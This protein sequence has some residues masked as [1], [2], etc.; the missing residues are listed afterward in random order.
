LTISK[1]SAYSPPERKT[2]AK[3]PVPRTGLRSTSV[4]HGRL[5][6][7]EAAMAVT[8]ANLPDGIRARLSVRAPWWSW[9]WLGFVYQP[10]RG[11]LQ[12]TR[13]E[14]RE[15][16]KWYCVW[17]CTVTQT[18]DVPANT[19]RLVLEGRAFSSVGATLEQLQVIGPTE[20]SDCSSRTLYAHN[21][22]FPLP[23]WLGGGFKGVG[24]RAQVN[25]RGSEAILHDHWGSAGP[26]PAD[27]L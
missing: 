1:G 19:D 17:L 26:M 7:K 16:R 10:V 13:Q 6:A 3:G 24:F 8:S 20:C 12:T 27:F 4:S 18:V 25:H 2:K 14:R 15:V 11:L 5:V 23:P 9:L 21:F 22:G